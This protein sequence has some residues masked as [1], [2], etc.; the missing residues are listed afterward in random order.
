MSRTFWDAAFSDDEPLKCPD[1]QKDMI[2]TEWCMKDKKAWFKCVNGH[3]W[4][5]EIEQ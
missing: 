3:I 4:T 1:C 2:M 5:K